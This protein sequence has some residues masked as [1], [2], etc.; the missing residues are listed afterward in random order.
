VS[1]T[2]NSS[3]GSKNAAEYKHAPLRFTFV[4]DGR[5]EPVKVTEPR[6]DVP[7]PEKGRLRIHEGRRLLCDV[8]FVF[9]RRKPQPYELHFDTRDGRPCRPARV[10]SFGVPLEQDRDLLEVYR[11]EILDRG[12]LRSAIRMRRGKARLIIAYQGESEVPLG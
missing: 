7:F 10:F 9:E 8:V 2:G 11:Q 5:E 3:F 6:V 12:G 1:S 4:L